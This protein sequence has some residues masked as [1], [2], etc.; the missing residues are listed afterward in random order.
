MRQQHV[1]HAARLADDAELLAESFKES[2]C[3][4]LLLV[5]PLSFA[6]LV[7]LL[8]APKKTGDF[9]CS[10]PDRG[11]P[12]KDRLTAPTFPAPLEGIFLCFREAPAR[13]GERAYVREACYTSCTTAQTANYRLRADVECISASWDNLFSFSARGSEPP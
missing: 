10:F 4:F 5:L 7:V 9:A 1:E 13:P 2:S 8:S 3:V 12:G 11:A 6:R